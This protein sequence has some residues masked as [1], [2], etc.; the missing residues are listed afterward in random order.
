[1]FHDIMIR[2]RRDWERWQT[3][4]MRL[5]WCNARQA[6]S[7]QSHVLCRASVLSHQATQTLHS[8]LDRNQHGLSAG[9]GSLTS[10]GLNSFSPWEVG[11]CSASRVKTDHHSVGTHCS[12]AA[13]CK[14]KKYFTI[15]N[16][17]LSQFC[18]VD[19]AKVVSYPY[20]EFLIQVS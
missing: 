6:G 12:T 17:I 2:G 15:S 5:W 9:V 14:P 1:M 7:R 10:S 20:T 3:T 8:T 13:N 19:L 4:R 16:L 11:Q 18:V